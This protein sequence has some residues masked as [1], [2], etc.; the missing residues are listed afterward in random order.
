[1]NSVPYDVQNSYRAYQPYYPRI[2]FTDMSK[3]ITYHFKPQD[4]ITPLE[5]VRL[6]E[7]FATG[8]GVKY[9]GVLWLEFIENNKLERH[10]TQR[11]VGED[12]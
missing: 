11:M 7:L 9:V 12:L 10:F 2:A 6:A 3:G 5:S 8:L 4:D 1:M